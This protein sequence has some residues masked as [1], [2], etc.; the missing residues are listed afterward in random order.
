VRQRAFAAVFAV[1]VVTAMLPAGLAT[2]QEQPTSYDRTFTEGQELIG[3]NTGNFSGD[4]TF[5]VTAGDAPG[6]ATT[7]F[8]KRDLNV[9]ERATR[10]LRQL[11]S[12]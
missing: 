1:L 3:V 7:P 8:I 12:V 4:F 5:Q 2:A 11:R 6:G 9:G 10:L